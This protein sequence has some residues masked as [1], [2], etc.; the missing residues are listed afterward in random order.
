MTLRHLAVVMPAYNEAEGIRDFIDEIRDSVSPVVDRVTFHIADDRSTDGTATVFDDVE[1]V[2]VEVQ[3]LNRGHG[4]TALAAYRAGLAVEP[5]VLVHVDGDGQFHGRD[6]PRLLAALDAE[7]ADVV[8]G[9]RDGRT[10]PWYR[11]V[12]TGAVG[13]LIALAAG[14]RIPDV[15]TPL[16]AYRTPALRAL[17][18]ATPADASVPHVHF[19]LAE[20]RAGFTVRYLRVDSIPRRGASATGTMWGRGSTV[21]LPPKRL[22]LFVRTAL[23][24]AWELSLRPSA[25]LRSIHRPETVAR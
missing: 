1:D 8:H 24:E 22:R 16:R 2:A 7:N 20:A 9:V 14:R 13:L 15:N 21:A 17:V 12:L 4:P 10:D 3:P 11:K 18:E 6:F 25:P 23:V 19:S 5:D